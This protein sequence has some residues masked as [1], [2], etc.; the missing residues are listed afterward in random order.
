MTASKVEKRF[1]L[2]KSKA[3]AIRAS[4]RRGIWSLWEKPKRKSQAELW[5]FLWFFKLTVEIIWKGGVVKKAL[6][7]RNQRKI[8]GNHLSTSH[9]L[10]I[11]RIIEEDFK[12]M[13]FCYA[14]VM[15]LSQP[16][17]IGLHL[18]EGIS[19][20]KWTENLWERCSNIGNFHGSIEE[21]SINQKKNGCYDSRN[22]QEAV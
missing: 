12:V 6:G 5:R 19:V 13:R 7:T 3:W 21:W 1:S 8:Y 15:K 2:Q 16:A 9:L 17:A 18:K 4:A 22:C 10:L 11:W 14:T 20:R